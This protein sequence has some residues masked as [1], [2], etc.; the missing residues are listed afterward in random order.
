MG[1]GSV[2]V[3]FFICMIVFRLLECLVVL[4]IATLIEKKIGFI[5]IYE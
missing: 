3:L 5:E 1:G 2:W 4:L